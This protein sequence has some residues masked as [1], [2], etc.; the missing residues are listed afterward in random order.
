M[1]SIS[2][3][4][5]CF[6]YMTCRRPFRLL[7]LSSLFFLL[8]I[9]TSCEKFSGDQEI[10][11][12]LKI[13]SISFSTDYTVQG[14]ASHSITDAWVYVDGEL[15]GT[16]PLPANLPVLK[17]GSHVV[18]I[19]P[20]IKK[21]GIAATRI[22]YPFYNTIE[23]TVNLIPDGSTSIVGTSTVYNSQTN[24]MWQEDFEG[25]TISLD[26]TPRSSVGIRKTIPGSPLTFEREH[27]GIVEMDSTGAFFE[28]LSHQ[29]FNIPNS[30]VFLEMDFN[31][32]NHL[33]VGIMVYTGSVRYQVPIITL[34]D[35]GGK[36]KKIYIDL[37]TSLNAYLGANK[38]QVVFGNYKEETVS[39][40]Q[41]LLDNIKL[42]SI[43]SGK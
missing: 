1:R 26:T 8:Q 3:F 24:F 34:F 25:A 12:Y 10:A 42:L 2:T 30:E 14:S 13:D 21:D 29:S 11:S 22:N 18:K 7:L 27:S 36:W 4:L 32:N 20:G 28:C 6:K 37:T 17:Q 23:K 43:K 15:I 31:I 41:I 39:Y 40:A 9:F 38:F 19:L 16:F 35:T 5:Q 33:T